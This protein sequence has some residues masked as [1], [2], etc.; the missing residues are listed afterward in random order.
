[1][2]K[3]QFPFEMKL[4]KINQ[5][6]HPAAK[7]LEIL[8]ILQGKAVILMKDQR[9]EL[10]AD[11]LLLIN[12]YHS[13]QLIG[14][15]SN[16]ILRLKISP[17]VAPFFKENHLPLFDDLLQQASLDEL[18][19]IL[20]HLMSAYFKNTEK[21]V[22]EAYQYFFSLLHKLVQHH[23]LPTKLLPQPLLMPTDH[24]QIKQI[25]EMI[26]NH[27]TEDLTLEAAAEE[28]Q[29]SYHYVSRLF[30]QETGVTFT[31]YLNL[32]RLHYALEELLATR[33]TIFKIAINNGFANTKQFNQVFKKRF[34]LSPGKYREHYLRTREFEE[35]SA[36][37]FHELNHGEALQE[38]ARYLVKKEID[39]EIAEETQRIQLNAAK[40]PMRKT[41][42]TRKILKIGAAIEGLNRTVQAEIRLIQKELAF[43]TAQIIGFCEETN[44]E[45][46][47]ILISE[48]IRNN[49]LFDFL[50]EVQLTP[51]IKLRPSEKL[52]GLPEIQAWCD[53]QLAV[54]RHLA[55]RYGKAAVQNWLLEWDVSQ[56][57]QEAVSIG[58]WGYVYLYRQ[59]KKILPELKVGVLSLVDLDPQ[60]ISHFTDFL[61]EQKRQ[62]TLPS[63]ISFEADPYLT[64]TIKEKHATSFKAYQAE[65]LE[66]LKKMTKRIQQEPEFSSWDPDFFLTDWNTLVG[67][68]NTYSG[69]YFRAALIL[70][71]L[72]WLVNEVA[73]IA[74]WLNIKIK[75]R[76]SG[77]REDNCMSVFLYL[78]LKR[79]LY[80]ALQFLR[81]LRGEVLHLGSNHI[82]TRNEGSY[83]LL[84]YNASHLD[85][86]HAINSY[87]IHYETKNIHVQLKNLPKSRY[88]IRKYILDK[89]HGSVYNDWIQIGDHSELDAE[90]LEYLAQKTLPQFQLSK[91]DILDTY[92][93]ESLLTINA[94]HLYVFQSIF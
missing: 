74:C 18:K 34:K 32:V 73:G 8:L 50:E 38:L 54:L 70:D 67:E 81:R 5:L 57:P 51:L 94:C 7:D 52:Q 87:Q 76:Q 69:A 72:L 85:P 42:Q 11:D 17:E 48:H 80:F 19:E 49:Q 59:V 58:I 45:N 43:D 39:D 2:K 9:I 12:P 68:G 65:F 75:E 24:P 47:V 13:Y 93:F 92:E 14:E 40:I 64:P 21:T 36:D 29:R 30:K 6:H 79:P 41:I 3:D 78:K 16:L 82:L 37:D 28:I 84:L 20:A 86:I 35:L 1:M 27:Y 56:L 31:E 33:N 23:R 71:D 91:E 55:N 15:T 88:S 90:Q 62:H 46:D 83:R 66:V 44:V 10:K 4:V 60:Q 63:F 26:Q 25:Q 61:E 77:K 89:D 22:L 53:E